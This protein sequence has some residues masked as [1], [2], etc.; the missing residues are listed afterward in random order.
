MKKQNKEPQKRL[1]RQRLRRENNASEKEHAQ[2][3]AQAKK[4][5]FADIEKRMRDHLRA[6]SQLGPLDVSEIEE[7][8]Q[9]TAQRCLRVVIDYTGLTPELAAEKTGR[10]QE[11]I[12]GVMEKPQGIWDYFEIWEMALAEH[13]D[14]R[15][16]CVVTI[17]ILI[18]REEMDWDMIHLVADFGYIHLLH[19]GAYDEPDA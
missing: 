7:A 9:Q 6:I 11:E 19:V 3:E 5:Y 10:S 12:A 14:I 8:L 18:D 4:D 2:E 15:D 1:S 17:Q 13:K 16:K